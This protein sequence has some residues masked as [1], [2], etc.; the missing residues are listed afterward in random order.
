MP[1]KLYQLYCEICNWKRI[2]DGSDVTDMTELKISSIP[3]GSPKLDPITKKVIEPKSKKPRK[4]FK[5]PKC[6]RAVIPRQ[7]NDPQTK[8]NEKNEELEKIKEADEEN[9][10]NGDKAGSA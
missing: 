3:G 5:C 7:I 4:R 8:M 9:R 1:T 10:I 6:G 2:T